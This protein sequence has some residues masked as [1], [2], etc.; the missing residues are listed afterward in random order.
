MFVF[1]TDSF[2]SLFEKRSAAVVQKKYKSQWIEKIET[3]SNLNGYELL[4]Q[5]FFEKIFKRWKTTARIFSKHHIE[6][7]KRFDVFCN[8]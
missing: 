7:R 1:V 2:M 8:L 6:V 3:H 4:K 5:I